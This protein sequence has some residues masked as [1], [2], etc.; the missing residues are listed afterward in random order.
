MG[1]ARPVTIHKMSIK[2]SIEERITE[3]VK[4]RL[5][6]TSTNESTDE[7][8]SHGRGNKS[9]RNMTNAQVAGALKVVLCLCFR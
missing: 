2:N 5:N 3:V 9:K 6:N 1:Q 7:E 8:P 4:K